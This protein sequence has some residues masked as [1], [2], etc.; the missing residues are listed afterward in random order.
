M[1]LELTNQ[2]KGTTG[3]DK[4]C[5]GFQYGMNWA[6]EEFL[7]TDKK[8]YDKVKEMTKIYSYTRKVVRFT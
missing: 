3:Q 5:R 8:N 1:A 7:K 6:A 4:Y 2:L